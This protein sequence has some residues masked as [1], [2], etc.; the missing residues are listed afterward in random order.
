MP[1]KPSL[2]THA[3]PLDSEAINS[4]NAP[5]TALIL[6]KSEGL[7]WGVLVALEM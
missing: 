3:M 2:Y 7:L 1:I 5:L 4:R 6:V